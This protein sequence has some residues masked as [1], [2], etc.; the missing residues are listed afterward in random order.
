MFDRMSVCQPR[1][2]SRLDSHHTD[3]R[4]FSSE[5]PL[6]EK[7]FS[8]PPPATSHWPLSSRPPSIYCPALGNIV[9]S[10]RLAS[11]AL[12]HRQLTLAT[13]PRRSETTRR[14]SRPFLIRPRDRRSICHPERRGRTRSSRQVPRE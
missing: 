10:H 4:P 9:L 5:L 14:R 8:W 12:S 1:T 3:C 2:V 6:F 11:R 7:E 13:S